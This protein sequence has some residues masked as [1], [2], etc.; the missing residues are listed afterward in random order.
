M[1][2]KFHNGPW[3]NIKMS[4]YQHR[5]PHCGDTTI[6]R[7]PHL[8]IVIFYTGKMIFVY[9]I[10]ALLSKEYFC[11]ISQKLTSIK[12]PQITTKAGER[13]QLWCAVLVESTTL[14][15]VGSIT[16]TNWGYS[17][18]RWGFTEFEAFIELY[19][20]TKQ[21]SQRLSYH[22]YP[23]KKR[24]VARALCWCHYVYLLCK[25]KAWHPMVIQP[26]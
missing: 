8:H 7:P 17:G 14:W 18:S 4:S 19:S 9:S 23:N 10:G 25:Y 21:T 2:T 15:C 11:K 1:S 12:P 22:Y 20:N 13:T 24:S 26:H 3:C 6:L 5:K 16:A